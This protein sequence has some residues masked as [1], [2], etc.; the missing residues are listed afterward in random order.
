MH[1]KIIKALQTC[2]KNQFCYGKNV[3]LYTEKYILHPFYPPPPPHK[4]KK[5]GGGGQNIP[6]YSILQRK[7]SNCI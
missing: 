6:V 5:K 2:V 1:E 3:I 4:N 7:K